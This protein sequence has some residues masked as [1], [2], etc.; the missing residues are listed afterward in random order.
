MERRFTRQPALAHSGVCESSTQ[1]TWASPSTNVVMG[2]GEWR[3]TLLRRRRRVCSSRACTSCA[4]SWQRPRIPMFDGDQQAVPARL[5]FAKKELEQEW[6]RRE[7]N[8]EIEIDETHLR[9][10]SGLGKWKEVYFRANCSLRSHTWFEEAEAETYEIPIIRLANIQG[11]PPIFDWRSDCCLIFWTY[12][13]AIPGSGA[14]RETNDKYL[15]HQRIGTLE[16]S[17]SPSGHMKID[18]RFREPIIDWERAKEM[19]IALE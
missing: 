13:K 2:F 10:E 9:T 7:V 17:N 5:R 3:N 8:A 1:A 15:I 16:T 14:L 4:S 12:G 19:T 18:R 6:Q 11:G